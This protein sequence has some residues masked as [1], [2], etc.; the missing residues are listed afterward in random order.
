[1]RSALKGRIRSALAWAVLLFPAIATPALAQE[2]PPAV[3][4]ILTVDQDRLYSRSLWGQRVEGEFAKV[5]ADLAAENRKIESEL[6][7]EEKDLTQ[8]RSTMPAAEFR[9]LADEFDLR[10]TAIRKAQ[11]EKARM[12]VEQRD[13]ARKAFFEGA[14]TVMGEVMAAR[15][16]VAILDSRAVF[17]SLDTI[18]AT[19]DVLKAV[20]AKL[21]AGP[22][23]P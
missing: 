5:S 13:I 19:D 15:G 12:V 18:D 22:V 11:D 6:I 9:K 17:L 1:M 23:S 21:G 4:A 7:T 20:D 2:T 10:V 3:S 14:L 16:A 8:K